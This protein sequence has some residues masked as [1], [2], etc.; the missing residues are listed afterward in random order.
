MNYQMEEMQSTRQG[1]V[2]TAGAPVPGELGCV[3]LWCGCVTL[4][5]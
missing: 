5:C 4:W 2:W 3:T 1:R